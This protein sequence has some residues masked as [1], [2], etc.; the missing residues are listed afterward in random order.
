METSNSFEGGISLGESRESEYEGDDED[1]ADE[2][3]KIRLG[4]DEDRGYE[5]KMSLE[6]LPFGEYTDREEEEDGDTISLGELPFGE[7]T[8]C[9]EEEDGDT[10]SLGEWP[11]GENT[12]CGEEEDGDTI[13]L[14]ELPFGEN[15]VCEEEEDGDTI[16]LGEFP[17]GRN[18]VCGENTNLGGWSHVGEKKDRDGGDDTSNFT[19][20]KRPGFGQRMFNRLRQLFVCGAN[21]HR[22]ESVG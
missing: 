19:M 10:I 21:L 20:Q 14:G 17:F 18:T 4:K 9:G 6:E 11:F 8:V 15:T 2:G 1:S 7:N 12:L 22:N 16:S 5:D 13:G 3:D